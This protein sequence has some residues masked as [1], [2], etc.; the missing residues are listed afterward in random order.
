MLRK[1]HKSRETVVGHPPLTETAELHYDFI[2]PA[3]RLAGKR[4][5]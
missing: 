5:N 4:S 3:Q 1:Q 2:S